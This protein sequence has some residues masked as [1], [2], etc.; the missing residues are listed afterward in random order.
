MNEERNKK[1]ERRRTRK[2]VDVT[3]RVDFFVGSRYYRA[4]ET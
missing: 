2:K 1:E 3:R 4:D